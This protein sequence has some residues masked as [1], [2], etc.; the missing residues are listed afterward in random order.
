MGKLPGFVLY[1]GDW[2]KD[3]EL[4]WLFFRGSREFGSNDVHYA[5]AQNDTG[6]SCNGSVF[7]RNQLHAGV[8]VLLSNTTL[9]PRTVA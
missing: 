6:T 3:P 1:P 5:R 7:L 2:L 8:D 9:P 4:R